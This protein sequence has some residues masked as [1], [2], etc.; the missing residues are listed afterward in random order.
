MRS[1]KGSAGANQARIAGRSSGS[2]ALSRLP[3]FFPRIVPVPVP[4]PDLS[5]G[6]KTPAVPRPVATLLTI[7]SI[8]CDTP[9]PSAVRESPPSSSASAT[10]AAPAPILIAAPK[11]LP[12]GR[13]FVREQAAAHPGR[14]VFVYVGATWC[15]PCVRFHDALTRGELDRELPNTLFVELDLDQ[16]ETAL[17]PNDLA[18]DGKLVPRFARAEPDG[19]CGP[20]R[21]EGAIKGEGAVGVILPRLKALL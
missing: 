1:P 17:D 9:N 10:V 8:A 18:C 16:H 20:R 11:N 5:R 15:E 7:L 4:V 13:S 14:T 6:S 3:C 2:S 12:D 21:A 19:T